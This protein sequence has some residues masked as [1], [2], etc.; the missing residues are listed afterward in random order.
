M[1]SFMVVS[2]IVFGGAASLCLAP[3]DAV[4]WETAATGP[5]PAGFTL[6]HTD[7]DIAF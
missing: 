5:E 7:V 6:V 2:V 1:N 3:G 4:T